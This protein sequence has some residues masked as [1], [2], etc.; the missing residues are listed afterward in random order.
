MGVLSFSARPYIPSLGLCCVRW[1]CRSASRV[2]Y[3]VWLLL[4][5]RSSNL[6]SFRSVIASSSLACHKLIVSSYTSSDTISSGGCCSNAGLHLDRYHYSHRF[7]HRRR[8]Y[9]S[10]HFQER[11]CFRSDPQSSCLAEAV[12]VSSSVA[13]TASSLTWQTV[14][15]F[16]TSPYSA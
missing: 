1:T 14:V 13:V 16:R 6:T 7:L 2:W 3:R 5:Y 9:H 4:A 8:S 10:H 12:F 15:Q 11:T